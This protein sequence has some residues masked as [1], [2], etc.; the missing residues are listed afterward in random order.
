MKHLLLSLSLSLFVYSALVQAQTLVLGNPSGAKTDVNRPD[1]YLVVHTGFILSYNR[2]RGAANW[3]AWHLSATDLGDVERASGFRQDTALPVAWRVKNDDYT[4][5][6]FDRGHMC[7]SEDRSNTEE[8][9]RE[10]FMMSNVQPQTGRLNGGPWKALEGEMQRL[11]RQG[12]EAYMYAGCYGSDGHR[13]AD[14]VTVPTRCWKVIV[15]LT[16]GNNDLRRIGAN[17]RVIAVEMLNTIDAISGW[18]N[19]RT[20]VDAIEGATGLN[21]LSRIRNDIEDVLESRLD[22][23]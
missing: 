21:L 2:S 17:T 7:P 20:T 8:A 22:D 13:I 6:G 23:Q 4:N 1:N 10:T 18:R 9:N 16:E 5:S 11:V 19:H 3:V 14:K 15:L 12:F